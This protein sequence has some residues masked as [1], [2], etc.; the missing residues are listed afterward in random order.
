MD[1]G[2]TQIV[3]KSVVQPA[4]SMSFRLDVNSKQ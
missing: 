4:K 1:T 3:V 2:R